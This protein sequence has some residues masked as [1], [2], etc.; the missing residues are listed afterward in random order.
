MGSPSTAHFGDSVNQTEAQCVI[1]DWMRRNALAA[2]AVSLLV[3]SGCSSSPQTGTVTGVFQTVGGAPGFGPHR[4]P[5]IVV[6]T[7]ADGARTSVTVRPDG[8]LSVRLPPGTYRAV[9]HSPRVHSG[10]QE[11]TCNAL[12]PVV[13]TAGHTVKVTVDCQLI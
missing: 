11:L 7:D 9:G 5:G 10:L 12:R 4:L 13:V 8:V 2:L 3:L 6:F 1:F